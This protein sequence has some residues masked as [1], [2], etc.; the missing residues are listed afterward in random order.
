MDQKWRKPVL[1]RSN[2]PRISRVQFTE[3]WKKWKKVFSMSDLSR[4]INNAVEIKK[5]LQIN[6]VLKI[7]AYWTSCKDEKPRGW[8]MKQT[9][10]YLA[11]K[12]WTFLISWKKIRSVRS[13]S[14]VGFW[15]G[16]Q[17][18]NLRK[19]LRVV[20]FNSDNSHLAESRYESSYW[21]YFWF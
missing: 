13:L 1:F 10:S 6:K 17:S 4:K 12:F 18:L 5:K 11:E 20:R 3:S 8:G 16:P 21:H 9:C 7:S 2:E 14:S 19:V 15:G